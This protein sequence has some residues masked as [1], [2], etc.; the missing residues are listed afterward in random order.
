MWIRDALP[1]RLPNTRFFLYGYDTALKGNNRSKQTILDL[2]NSLMQT[3][4]SNE[5]SSPSAKP[6]VFLAHS[7]GGV[8]LKQ[9][10]LFL[11][12]AE[13]KQT[14]LSKIKG[15]ILFGV[16]SK[17]I[18]L[19]LPNKLIVGH[20]SEALLGQLSDKSEFMPTLESSFTGISDNNHMKFVWAYESQ[21]IQ[22]SNNLPWYHPVLAASEPAHVRVPRDSATGGLNFSSPTSVI[23]IN[24][25]HSNMVKFPE[26][27]NT[28][29]I[30]TA[31]MNHICRLSGDDPRNERD[32]SQNPAL[33]HPEALLT[34]FES[35]STGEL[36]AVAIED[37]YAGDT[38]NFKAI[39]DSF[40]P[41]GSDDRL[42]QITKNYEDTFEWVFDDE[43]SVGFS[44]W[45]QHEHEIF[46]IR[47]KPGSGKSTLM[48]FMLRSTNQGTFHVRKI[49]IAH[50]HGELLLPPPW[51]RVTEQKYLQRARR[52]GLQDLGSDIRDLIT[53]HVGVVNAK[54]TASIQMLAELNATTEL[55]RI[56]SPL[57]EFRRCH[58]GGIDNLLRLTTDRL[59]VVKR[60]I[61]D[62]QDYV[63][64]WW[65]RISLELNILHIMRYAGIA[66]DEKIQQDIRRI[67]KLEEMRDKIRREVENEEWS[68]LD[69]ENGLMRIINQKAT[70]L[71]I[72]LFIDALDEYDGSPEL[73]ASFIKDLVNQSAKSTTKLKICVSSRQLETFEKHFKSCPGFRIHDYTADDMR[74]FCTGTISS[75]AIMAHGTSLLLDLVP[76]IV[77]RS[78][79]VFLWTKLV[80]Y[81]LMQITEASQEDK[82]ALERHLCDTLASL[83]VDLE[84]YYEAIIK[85]MLPSSR[86]KTY[87]ILESMARSEGNTMQV[88]HAFYIMECADIATF[89]ECKAKVQELDSMLK[90]DSE[91]KLAEQ[92]VM[93]MTGGLVDVI[94]DPTSPVSSA[95]RVQFMH[96]TVRN[97]V[98]KEPHFKTMIL[99]ESAINTFDNGHAFL[100]KLNF[101]LAKTKNNRP[102]VES[103]ENFLHVPYRAIIR[104][105]KDAEKTTGRSQYGF[106]SSVP[107][108]F[109]ADYFPGKWQHSS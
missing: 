54:C 18:D 3:L 20:P 88:L 37:G 16:P 75:R 51:K 105:A 98:R 76:S 84:Q 19:E 62:F 9:T 21:P 38:W 42:K 106:I 80:L 15:G 64:L 74:R 45:L 96:Q 77:D 36:S 28:L 69:L 81:D 61:P 52:Q 107:D 5:W 59:S 95:K 11:A 41:P 99:G 34:A 70:N 8:V 65:E 25:D 33:I 44:K 24:K 2:A 17:G 100:M 108:T 86:R 93:H 102:S 10:I 22:S 83:P 90:L 50:D 109:F 103:Y 57:N 6:L 23:H 66:I 58:T 32:T 31:R 27:D 104:H 29:N 63:K 46:W 87:A 91:L 89:A 49:R 39:V 1:K 56:M 30:I 48:K 40:R 43:F 67:I 97:F 71:D 35:S 7:L 68:R 55:R 60:H 101:M 79:G 78:Q 13:E 73:I 4:L 82:D 94:T 12:D 85:R 72:C 14:M 47:G 92:K 53:R 26:D